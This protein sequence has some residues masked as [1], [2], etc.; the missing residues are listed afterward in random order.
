MAKFIRICCMAGLSALL[1]CLTACKDEESSTTDIQ[2]PQAVVSKSIKKP[3][4]QS[5]KTGQPK[6]AKKKEQ[7]KNKTVTEKSGKMSKENT[8]ENQAVTETKTGKS[9]SEGGGTVVKKSEISTTLAKYDTKG[10]VDPFVPLLREKKEPTTAAVGADGKPI[11]LKPKRIL[12][13]LEKMDIS[14]I[15]L[16]AVIEMKGRSVA[17]VEEASGKGY[18]VGIGTYMGK[19]NGQVTAINSDG[20]MVKEYVRDFKGILRERLQ[21]IKFQKSEEEE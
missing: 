9:N 12:T 10:R 21:E 3:N 16:V 11:K 20:I 18:E 14:Q 7:P 17:M 4:K 15:K 1:L 5:K 8:S 19:N 2:Q 13:P 6:I